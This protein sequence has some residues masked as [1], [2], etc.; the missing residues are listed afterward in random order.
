MSWY[1]TGT[2]TV[3]TGSKNV[4]GVGTL[5]A[6]SVNVGDAFALV[7]ANG[8]PTGAWYEVE[9]VTSNTALVLK[10]T[11]TGTPAPGSNKQYVVFNLVGNMTTPSF[12]QRLAQFF[13]QFQN[14]VDLPTTTPTASSI[15]IADSGGK[16]DSAWIKDATT[17][18]KGV[19]KVGDSLSSASGVLSVVPASTTVKGAVELATAAEAAAGNDTALAVTPAGALELLK[20]WGLGVASADHASIQVIDV[21]TDWN[22]LTTS[23]VYACTSN[24]DVNSPTTSQAGYLLLVSNTKTGTNLRTQQTAVRMASNEIFFRSYTGTEWTPWGL[25]TNTVAVTST[26]DATSATAAPLK[27]AGGLAVA[28]KGIFGQGIGFG[29]SSTSSPDVTGTTK[30]RKIQVFDASGNSIGYLQVYQG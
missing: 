6:S 16:I 20:K 10:Q 13:D 23:G 12:A 8:N 15:P 9:E 2:V 17:A 28:K 19:V 29:N 1:R 21:A 18:V 11:Y 5:W 27:S 24:T 26:D 7:D 3:A 4:T 25:N 14:L 30:V 22:T